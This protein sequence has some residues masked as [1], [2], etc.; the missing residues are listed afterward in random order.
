MELLQD[1]MINE[2]VEFIVP[3]CYLICFSVAYYGPNAN[4][5]G[6]VRNNQWQFVAVDDFEHTIGF[7]AL[8]FLADLGSIVVSFLC[9]WMFTRIN[10]WSVYKVVQGEFGLAFT[11]NLITNLNGVR[12]NSFLNFIFAIGSFL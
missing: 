6:N 11:S 5:I 1:L 10:L 2:I 4:L 9:L 12:K 7:I 3:L 8:F